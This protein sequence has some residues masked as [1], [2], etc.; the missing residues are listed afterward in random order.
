[1]NISIQ[2]R[3]A[4]WT[5]LCLLLVV[6]TTTAVGL[7]LFA[8]VKESLSESSTATIEEQVG[9][10]LAVLAGEVS[11]RV[12]IP[13]LDALKSAETTASAITAILDDDLNSISR[14]AVLSI[15]EQK[16]KDNQDYLG[17]FVAFE[18]NAFD[19]EDATNRAAVGSDFNGRFMP[20]VVRQGN[21]SA[22]VEALEGLEDSTLDE[23]GMRAGEYYLCPRDSNQSCVIDPYLYPVDGVEELLSSLVAPV[24]SNG[25][26]VGISGVDVSV[27]F[28][29]SITETANAGLYDGAG[30]VALFSPR[31]VISGSSRFADLIGTNLQSI[32]AAERSLVQSASRSGAIQTSRIG[33][34]IAVANPFSMP[35]NADQWVVLI[36]VPERL[37]LAAVDNQERLLTDA[38]QRFLGSTLLLGLLVGGA[39][40]L[41]V[42]VVSRTAMKPLT[43]M[44][45]LVASIAEGEGDLTHQI[46]IKRQDET[47]KLAGYLNTFIGKLAGLIRETLPLGEEVG[48]LAADGRRI[49]NDTSAQVEE[50]RELINQVVTAVTE[51]SA[52]AQEIAESSARTSDYA[53]QADEYALSGADVVKQTAHAIAQVNSSTEQVQH[54]M[55]ILTQHSDDIV[56]ILGVI[57]A[58]AEQTNLLAL[59]A[60][61]EAAR[62]GEQGR[63]FAVVADEVRALA[64]RT[65][66]ATVDINEKLQA[67]QEGSSKAQSSMQASGELVQKTVALSAE[68]EASIANIKQAV[69]EIRSMTYQIATATEEQSSVCEDVSKNMTAIS[70]LVEETSNGAIQLSDVGAKLDVAASGLGSR[71]NQFKV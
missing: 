2:Q 41:I 9:E 63:G 56:G 60:A 30:Q 42:W 51:M 57:Q 4:L 3:V 32:S 1:M 55:T 66:D 67:L 8:N 26:F 16:L 20:Y 28:L 31:G 13:I 7:Y 5:G 21:N 6:T 23:N 17:T 12:E 40:F 47:G 46:S 18:P 69:D 65:Q 25:R 43:I 49:S 52:A 37:A 50:Q 54:A 44:T 10:Y 53:T 29:Q 70:S 11:A 14:R 45:Q 58:I 27:N 15:L 35:G 71:L 68:A 59:N 64:A 48:A 34:E 62:A 61:I 38:Q 33:Q 39:G 36:S 24:R 22:F 19:G